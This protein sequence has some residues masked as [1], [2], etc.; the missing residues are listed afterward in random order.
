MKLTDYTDAAIERF[1]GSTIFGR[2]YGYYEEGMVMS[3]E[4]DA[5][6]ETIEAQVAGH[7]DDYNVSLSGTQNGIHA[8]CDCPYDGWPCKHVVA[9]LL[10]FIHQKAHYVKAHKSRKK[11]GTSLAAKIRKLSQDELAELM[12]AYAQKYPDVKRELMVRLESH[13]KATFETIQKQIGNAFPSIESRNY[14]TSTIAKQLSTIVQSV[15]NASPEMRVKVLWAA[16]DAAIS[17][18]NAYGMYDDPLEDFAIEALESLVEMLTENTS[19]HELKAR[20]IDELMAYYISGNS[21]LVDFMYETASAL[22]SEDSDCQ[23]MIEHLKRS[24]SSYH[25]GLLARWYAAIG[26]TDAQRTTL[27]SKLEYGMDYWSL[28]Q[29]WFDQGNHKKAFGVIL[30]G[31]EHGKGRKLEL[32]EALQTHYQ[33]Q[34]EYDKIVKLLHQK[35]DKNELDQ[36]ILRTDGAYQCLWQ[37]YE[38]THDYSQH[39]ALLELCVTNNEVDLDLYKQAE[40]TLGDDDWNEFAPKLITNLQDRIAQQQ[41][42]QRSLSWSYG[43]SYGRSETSILADI[44]HYTQ[45]IDKLFET[46]NGRVDLL[47][48]YE[49]LLLPHY[50]VEYLDAYKDRINRLIAARGRKNY[51]AA[52]PYVKKM[53]EIYTKML[54]SPADWKA[55]ITHLRTS[56]KTLRAL[57]DELSKMVRCASI[58]EHRFFFSDVTAHRRGSGTS[59]RQ[60]CVSVYASFFDTG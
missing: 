58:T 1:A 42:K 24:G 33:Q 36:R 48:K 46:V 51:Q 38:K 52:V 53:K 13:K 2:G 20:I 18:L 50:A 32:Y 31:I 54:E 47:Q 5:D 7:Y 27:E 6:S 43:F 22:C 41:Q 44:Y 14:S 16:A 15:D 10:T 57:Q 4:Y 12:I 8:D 45:D 3:L 11:S 9:V 39:K 30:D 55:Y 35:I 59:S 60:E 21:G 17:E 28:A 25:Q 49:S 56:N 29:Y 19:L 37:H 23:I 26:D 40:K 34:N